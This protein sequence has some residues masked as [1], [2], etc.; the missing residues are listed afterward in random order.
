M[1][2][3][4]RKPFLR[5]YRRGVRTALRNNSLAFGY[6]I[7]VTADFAVLNQGTDTPGLGRVFAFIVGAVAAFAALD[8]LAAEFDGNHERGEPS[9]VV[10]LGSAL[11]FFSISAGVGT[12][13]LIAWL[14][15]PWF[16][17]PLAAFVSSGTYLLIVGV[18]M[19]LA[20][21]AEQQ[22]GQK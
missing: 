18:E 20:E 12:T 1:A 16:S 17:W 11:S 3:G 19:A 7:V 13:A 15:E 22:W 9:D 5:R 10:A 14:V 4:S 6:S 2:R 21:Q 8:A